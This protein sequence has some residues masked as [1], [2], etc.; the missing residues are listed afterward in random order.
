MAMFV[1]V[2]GAQLGGWC[3]RKVT[4]LLRA[5]GHEVYTPTLTGVGERAHLLTR[6]VGLDLH[7]RDLAGVLEYEELTDIILVGHSYGGMVIT[8]VAERMPGR[9]RHLVY[10]DAAVTLDAAR[11]I[12]ERIIARAP[13]RWAAVEAQIAA[14]GDGWL[15]PAMR[16]GDP[17]QGVT[18]AADLR[19]LYAHVT[20]HPFRT[21]TDRLPGDHAPAAHIPR[22]FIRCPEIPGAPSAFTA[23]AERIRQMGGRVAELAGGHMVMVTK[24]QELAD[25]LLE[26]AALS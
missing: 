25:L 19:W 13:E 7:L 9:V 24:P 26:I 20:P 8:G 2:P 16:P 4:P 3:W 1:L 11:S 22:S 17:T 23:D 18:D 6:E 14:E 5:A 21:F 10:L 12:R 15:I